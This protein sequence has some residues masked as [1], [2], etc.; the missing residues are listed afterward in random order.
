MLSR[1]PSQPERSAGSDGVLSG[2]GLRDVS[3]PSRRARPALRR[4]RP[5]DRLCYFGPMSY[6]L[7]ILLKNSHLPRWPLIFGSND[8]SALRMTHHS[9]S[10]GRC[11][12]GSLLLESAGGLFQQNFGGSGQPAFGSLHRKADYA[13]ASANPSTVS[14][15]FLQ[16]EGRSTPR[17]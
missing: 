3:A 7:G 2:A 11:I 8:S 15:T 9:C 6:L 12:V 4:C 17:P 16:C 1:R 10:L 5:T 14:I 13:R